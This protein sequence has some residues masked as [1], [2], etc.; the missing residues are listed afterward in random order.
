MTIPIEAPTAAFLAVKQPWVK[1][2]QCLGQEAIFLNDKLKGYTELCR[3]MCAVC[4]VRQECG[5][6]A[7]V[8]EAGADLAGR[9]FVRAYMTPAQ[10]VSL[11]RRGG[12]K[13]RDPMHLV[14]GIDGDRTIPPVPDEGDR[15][16]KHHTTLARKLVRYLDDNVKRGDVIE[17]RVWLQ[18]ALNCNPLPLDRVLDALVQ[19]GT[20]DTVGALPHK[21]RRYVYRGGRGVV[22]SWLPVFLR[23]DSVT[24]EATHG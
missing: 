14:L 2:A 23:Y 4:P 7:M 20:L 10:R 16:S 21:N 15:W 22:G 8:E 17:K 12:L 24:L 6:Q 9:W 5:E 1:E 19:D 11:H 3:P 18:A 13:G